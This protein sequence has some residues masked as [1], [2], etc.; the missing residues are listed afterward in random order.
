MIIES[1]QNSNFK[2][3]K[4]LRKKK[5]RKENNLFIVEGKKLFKEAIFSDI[6]INSVI[7]NED[8]DVSFVKE[9]FQGNIYIVKNQLFKELSEMEHSEGILCVCEKKKYNLRIGKHVIIF[10]GIKD[11]GNAGTIIRS[12]EAFGFRDCIFINDCVDPYNSKVV[13][14]SM[15]SIFRLNLI[16]EDITGKLEN[17]NYTFL[18]LDMGG[19]PLSELKQI[20]KAAVI[21]GSEAHGVSRNMR[22]IAQETISIPMEGKIESLNAGIAASIIMYEL[23]K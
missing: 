2:L 11:P 14:G 7:L 10:D 6:L 4:S 12:A 18:A 17:E 20:E 1:S 9:V 16:E 19:S 23:N 5:Y 21:I 8:I 13:R 22:N 3:W 15:G